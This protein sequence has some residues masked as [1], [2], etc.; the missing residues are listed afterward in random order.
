MTRHS[1]AIAIAIGVCA[2]SGSAA[3]QHAAK[4]A[5]RYDPAAETTVSGTVTSV[6][7]AV[8]PGGVVGVH[9]ELKTASG[10]IHV[11]VGPATFIGDNNFYFIAEDVVTVVGAK[12]GSPKDFVVWA[13][14]VA[15]GDQVLTLRNADGTPRWTLATADDPDGCGVPHGPIR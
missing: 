8:S 9:L 13:R 1:V 6:I 3:A 10:P 11:S 7:S 15:K 12:V 2:L 5:A 4:A 14:Q